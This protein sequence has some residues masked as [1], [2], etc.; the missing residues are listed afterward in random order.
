[1]V[2]L[3]N[4][5]PLPVPIIQHQQKCV[6]VCRPLIPQRLRSS[7]TVGNGTP[8]NAFVRRFPGFLNPPCVVR[9]SCEVPVEGTLDCFKDFRVGKHT[10]P[11]CFLLNWRQ[12][13]AQYA[14]EVM[15]C[16]NPR[17]GD[18]PHCLSH[19]HGRVQTSIRR[20]P[21]SLR[22]IFSVRFCQ[23]IDV[24]F[25]IICHEPNGCRGGEDGAPHSCVAHELHVP[26]WMRKPGGIVRNLFGC[27]VQSCFQASLI[28]REDVFC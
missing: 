15:Q 23:P 27:S 25:R 26:L 6:C 8:H 19:L 17:V 20:L 9:A 13:P 16:R 18:V 12:L 14:P 21:G 5:I 22:G 3:G 24:S 28:D 11:Q 4:L 1:M 2:D 7:G 10:Q